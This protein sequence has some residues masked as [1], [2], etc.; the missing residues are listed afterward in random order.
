MF[1]LF[2]EAVQGFGSLYSIALEMR[3]PELVNLITS[4]EHFRDAIFFNTVYNY[5]KRVSSN[6]Y[7]WALIHSP[8]AKMTLIHGSDHA[9]NK[10]TTVWSKDLCVFCKYSCLR[11]ESLRGKGRIVL[12]ILQRSSMSTKSSCGTGDKPFAKLLRE[13]TEC[14]NHLQSSPQGFV[15]QEE[16]RTLDSTSV[17]HSMPWAG[18]ETL[19]M[20]FVVMKVGFKPGIH[21][22]EETTD[23]GSPPMR[24]PQ[25]FLSSS[26]QLQRWC[27]SGFFDC[28]GLIY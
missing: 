13:P 10:D 17:L 16:M 20:W 9:W 21:H 6:F 4:R 14:W 19:T 11:A 24:L 25:W 26:S 5:I 12:K 3:K 28:F 18:E 15:P 7:D 22:P 1:C 8:L 2:S 23:S 27:W